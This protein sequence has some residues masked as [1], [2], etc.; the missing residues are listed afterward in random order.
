MKTQVRAIQPNTAAGD[1]SLVINRLKTKQCFIA[2]K[3][4]DKYKACSQQLNKARTL[5]ELC[6]VLNTLLDKD[7]YPDTVIINILIRK[8]AQLKQ[9]A[10]ADAVYAISITN[11][12]ANVVT[13]NSMIDATGKNGR[14]DLALKAYHQATD[15]K[16]DVANVVTHSSM[17]DVAGKNGRIDLALQA[18]HQAIDP[19]RYVAN[20]VTHNSMIDAAGKNGRIDLALQAYHQATDPAHDVAN[21]V[22]HSSMI[23]A[24]GKNGRLDLALQAYHKATDPKHN[25]ADVVTH[26]IM[27]DAA[28]KNGRLDLALKAYHKATDPEHYVANVVTHSSMIDAA[29]RNG[30]LDL[31]LQAYHQATDPEHYI[32]NVVTHSSMIDAAGKNG[33]LDLALQAYQKATDPKH[34]VAD[35]VTHNGMIDVL[36]M[37]NQINQAKAIYDNHAKQPLIRKA[38][39]IY[40]IDLHGLNYGVTHI[41]L[42]E[43]ID[44]TPKPLNIR[45]IYG[46]GLHS[47]TDA[48]IHPIK[49]ATQDVIKN[50]LQNYDVVLQEETHNFGAAHLSITTK[51]TPKSTSDP[52]TLSADKGSLAVS[53]PE[54][55]NTF[56]SSSMLKPSSQEFIPRGNNSFLLFSPVQN[57]QTPQATSPKLSSG[58]SRAKP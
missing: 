40:E 31:A 29:G 2:K 19:E 27:I 36:F 5:N 18:Y 37:N 14:I 16:H 8:L 57:T 49:S 21:V 47:K 35:V 26:N 32:A 17:I 33:R 25:V 52:N 55:P 41:A 12:L 4:F 30:R 7:L 1:F 15:P 42:S 24:A 51:A 34:Y 53:A 22:T 48:E 11:N 10:H 56:L 44:M 13:H 23:D 46:K 38:D 6:L 54:K 28:G 43:F 3:N 20:V 58:M 45:I 9:I 50:C 39:G